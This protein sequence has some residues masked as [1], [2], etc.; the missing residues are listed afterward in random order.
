MKIGVIGGGAWGTALAQVA[1]QAGGETLL[2]ALEADVV[3][4]INARHENATFLPASR[5]IR[6]SARPPISPNSTA[7]MP[8]W[9]SRPRNTCASVLE[10]APGFAEPLVLCAKGIEEKSGQLLH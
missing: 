2:W 8:G 3:E 5:S 7:A 10:R 1:R 4:A 6:R 9:S